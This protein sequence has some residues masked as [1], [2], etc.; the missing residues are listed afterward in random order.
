MEPNPNLRIFKEKKIYITKTFYHKA[1]DTFCFTASTKSVT[2][3]FRG[4][5]KRNWPSKGILSRND[6]DTKLL[7]SIY[8][9]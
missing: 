8:C 9:S 2:Q 6:L 1:I 7:Q 5:A 4:V 3:N